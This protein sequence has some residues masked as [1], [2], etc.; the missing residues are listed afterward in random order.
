MYSFFA[1]FEK[2]FKHKFTVMISKLNLYQLLFAALFILKIGDVGKYADFSWWWV[3]TPFILG[4]M[5]SIL[6]WFL[7]VMQIS[8]KVKQEAAKVYLDAVQK[9]ATKRAIKEIE[10]EQERTWKRN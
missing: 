2:K 1:I 3:F 8:E 10:K 7:N 4:V 9:K 5:H 6:M